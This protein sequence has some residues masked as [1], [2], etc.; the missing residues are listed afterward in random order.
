MCQGSWLRLPVN[1]EFKGGRYIK[2]RLY[3]VYLIALEFPQPE[4][5]ATSHDGEP[6]NAPGLFSSVGCVS[7]R[8]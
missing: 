3:N 2:S 1:G 5:R 4:S 6:P 8:L 7:D